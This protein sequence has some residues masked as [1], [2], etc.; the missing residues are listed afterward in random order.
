MELA[1]FA[2]RWEMKIR[3]RMRVVHARCFVEPTV[4]NARIQQSEHQIPGLNDRTLEL[5]LPAFVGEDGT[6]NQ[7]EFTAP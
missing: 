7:A 5:V 6:P 1:P 4:Y 2:T 3:R